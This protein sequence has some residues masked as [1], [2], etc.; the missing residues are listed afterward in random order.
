M[1]EFNFETPTLFDVLEEGWCTPAKPSDRG[2]INPNGSSWR[3]K[4]LESKLKALLT[5]GYITKEE[6]ENLIITKNIN[7]LDV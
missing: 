2:M 4:S 1:G 7:D 5:N 6:Y 3:Y